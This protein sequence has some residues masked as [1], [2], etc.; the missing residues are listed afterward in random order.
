MLN[1][2]DVTCPKYVGGFYVLDPATGKRD[3]VRGRLA[4]EDETHR[5]TGDSSLCKV[6]LDAAYV[7]NAKHIAIDG[8]LTNIAEHDRGIVACFKLPLN[9][10]G[11]KWWDDADLSV[12]VPKTPAILQNSSYASYLGSSKRLISIYPLACISNDSAGV[13]VGVAIDLPCVFRLNYDT[14][15]KSLNVYYELGL[16]RETLRFPSQAHFKIVLYPLEKP[17]WGFRSAL[18]TYYGIFPNAFVNRVKAWGFWGNVAPAK[19]LK[20][21][22]KAAGCAFLQGENTTSELGRKLGM[23][24]LRYCRPWIY[25]EPVKKV[26]RP[27]PSQAKDL[28]A[29]AA[30]RSRISSSHKFLYGPTSAKD[31]IDAVRNSVIHGSSGEFVTHAD[32]KHCG[33]KY[34][35]NPDHEIDIDGEKLNLSALSFEGMIAPTIQKVYRKQ[36]QPLWGLFY[37]VAGSVLKCENYRAE[38][39]RFADS[40]LTYDYTEKRP[41]LFGLSCAHEYLKFICAHVHKEGGTVGVNTSP[42]PYNMI[43]L[44][45]VSDMAG[46]E[47]LPGRREMNNRRALARRKYVGFTAF[48]GWGELL[49]K[50]L[51]YGAFPSHKTVGKGVKDVAHIRQAKPL[52]LKYVPLIRTVAK[53]GW[54][55][56][57]FARTSDGGVLVERYGNMD[58]GAVYFAVW[59][60][61]KST[62]SLSLTLDTEGLGVG[63]G[64]LKAENLVSGTPLSV[65]RGKVRAKLPPD[66]V[67]LIRLR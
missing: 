55:P 51:F 18:E 54:E 17:S 7:A 43:F 22:Y 14:R 32:K 6:R 57:T 58:E 28:L 3:V 21:E 65:R 4:K 5:F 11:F 9:A 13:A 48:E 66:E 31:M 42:Y 2:T 56:V 63:A 34:V 52:L 27:T 33:I 47:H 35:L 61:S 10:A 60:T 29:K 19:I 45:S 1:R 44:A 26:E 20:D 49:K 16:S 15:D 41:V 38:H 64:S 25:T 59:N 37:D 30:Q 67:A 8:T 46:T 12:S 40:P 50:G 23:Y 24:S 36:K 62:K 39:F 53:A